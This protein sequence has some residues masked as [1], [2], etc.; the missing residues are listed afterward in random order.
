MGKLI[1]TGLT[2]L[3]LASIAHAGEK[4]KFSVVKGLEVTTL[5][6]QNIDGAKLIET[7]FF[8][9]KKELSIWYVSSYTLI[10]KY[11]LPGP[12][13]IR[14]LSPINSDLIPPA[15]GVITLRYVKP[16]GQGQKHERYDF[17]SSNSP[18]SWR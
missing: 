15:L 9:G 7:K 5:Y 12:R 3:C 4:F 6:A 17:Y 18:Q 16:L 11:E 10:E 2:I 14:C 1:I 13:Y 8:S